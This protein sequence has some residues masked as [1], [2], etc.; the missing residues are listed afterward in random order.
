MAHAP[1]PELP[2]YANAPSAMVSVHAAQQLW[3][4]PLTFY[5]LWWNA[6]IDTFFRHMPRL[7]HP[8]HH[9]EH[10]QLVVPEPLEK[11]DE[12]ALFA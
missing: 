9:Q 4:M 6:T 8:P 10:D 7:P 5:T 3:A 11:T 1:A 12:H 2:R